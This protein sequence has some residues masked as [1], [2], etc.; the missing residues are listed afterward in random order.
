MMEALLHHQ[1]L[2]RQQHRAGARGGAEGSAGEDRDPSPFHHSRSAAATEAAATAAPVLRE[3]P[4]GVGRST[5]LKQLYI[6][7]PARPRAVQE[8]SCEAG[9]ASDELSSPSSTSS[10][11]L[12]VFHGCEFGAVFE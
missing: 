9:S 12:G 7:T 1:E 5:M 6:T 10:S 11:P 8:G 3:A 2:E 4:G